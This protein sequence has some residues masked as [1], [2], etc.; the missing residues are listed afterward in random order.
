M[1]KITRVFILAAGTSRRFGGKI[2]KQELLINGEKIIRRTIRQVLEY[3]SKLQIYILTWHKSLMFIDV[4]VINTKLRPQELSDTILLSRP[5][6]KEWNI[7]LL[8]DVV[9]SDDALKKIL[10]NNNGITIFGRDKCPTKPGSERFALS[11]PI[12]QSEYITNLLQRASKTFRKDKWEGHGGMKKICWSTH[13]NWLL[14]FVSD[15]PTYLF[16]RPFRDYFIYHIYTTSWHPASPTSLELINDPITTDIDTPEEY[17]AFLAL[18]V[19][20]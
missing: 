9:Y 6:W 7:I 18:G 19:T 10:S 4:N 2:L 20:Q 17:A 1:T 11:F 15:I 16:I 8:G 14:P 13:P 5:Y 12:E 3:N